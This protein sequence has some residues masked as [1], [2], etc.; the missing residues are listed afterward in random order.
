MKNLGLKKTYQIIKTHP[1]I[2]PF[3]FSEKL[4]IVDTEKCYCISILPKDTFYN[5][6]CV[7][8]VCHHSILVITIHMQLLNTQL[9]VCATQKMRFFKNLFYVYKCSICSA[10]AHHVCHSWV[11]PERALDP[12]GMKLQNKKKAI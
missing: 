2:I 12:L 10:S 5:N 7:S 11:V 9:L 6:M 1:F 4:I 8:P 3:N